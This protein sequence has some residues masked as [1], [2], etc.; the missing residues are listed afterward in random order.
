MSSIQE[1][2]DFLGDLEE[3]VCPTGMHEE[4]S[5][6]EISD[7]R[8]HSVLDQS[9]LNGNPYQTGCP[10]ALESTTAIS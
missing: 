4:N 2:R 9:G 3:V 6:F 10:A 1:L 7:A 5:S 8:K